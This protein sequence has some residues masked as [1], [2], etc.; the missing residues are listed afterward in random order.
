MPLEWH[1]HSVVQSRPEARNI[2]KALRCEVDME[3]YLYR[4]YTEYCPFGSLHDLVDDMAKDVKQ[5]PPEMW[6]WMAFEKLV[7]CGL[8]MEQGSV[9]GPSAS[10]WR[11]VVHRDLKP[12]NVF[13]DQP[14][15]DWPDMV[16]PKL[17]DFGFAIMTGHDDT[18]NPELY[19]RAGTH[20]YLVSA[21]HSKGAPEFR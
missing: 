17:G 1:I 5:T 18:M 20:G 8:I 19:T 7:D 6:L 4:F 9:D 13:I 15:D 21:S 3:K 16:Q 11:Q 10:D 14:G 12:D 2:V